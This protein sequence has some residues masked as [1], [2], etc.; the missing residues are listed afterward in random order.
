[1]TQIPDAAVQA[2]RQ[3]FESTD[4]N[5]ETYQD[6]RKALT[7]A[8]PYLSAPCA[9]AVP[10]GWQLVP[11]EPTF[12]MAKAAIHLDHKSDLDAK[13]KTMLSAA[14]QVVTKPVDVA[15]VWVTE[16]MLNAGQERLCQISASTYF[17]D[18]EQA[19]IFTAMLEASAL[20]AE[21]EQGA[22]PLEE[23]HEDHG[24]VVWW[25]WDENRKEWLG[26]PAYIGTPIDSD[27]PEYHTHWTPHPMRPTAPTSEAGR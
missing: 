20:S 21:P 4:N 7:A 22:R 17:N 18:H 26:E 6:V 14:P 11:K 1:M 24:N 25:V 12:E 10:E 15:A 19:E 2:F 8:L 13:Y 9:V 5:C 16:E 27:W 23:W 3:S